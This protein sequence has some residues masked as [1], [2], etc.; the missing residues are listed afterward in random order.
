MGITRRQ[1]LVGLGAAALGGG[2]FGWYRFRPTLLR[3]DASGALVRDLRAPADVARPEM[4]VATGAASEADPPA[5]TEKAIAAMG[6]L[7][8]FVQRGEVVLIKPN[9]GWARGPLTAA[10]TNAEVVAALVRG[11][12]RA[13]AKRVIVADGSCDA[14]DRAYEMSGIAAKASDAGAEV[15]LPGPDRWKDVALH[16]RRMESWPILAAALSADRVINVP[17]AKHHMLARYTGALKNWFGILGA[18][19]HQLHG[20]L[21]AAIADANRFLRPTLTVIDATRVLLRNG[22]KGGNLADTAQKNTVIVAVDPV[23]ADARALEL[24]GIAPADVAHL[25]TA[26]AEGLGT[27]DWKKLR[28]V[29][30]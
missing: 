1:V 5:L 18:D 28:V 13:G 12:L 3:R 16:G 10:N 29:Q 4:A 15:L 22:P 14:A 25:V 7:S 24:F 17:V 26:E 9:I 2:A 19:R 27:T 6:G 8:R 20:N 21:S 30:A 23:A 11:A